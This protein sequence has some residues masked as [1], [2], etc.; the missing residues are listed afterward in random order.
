MVRFALS[1]A[2][3]A[4]LV[5]LLTGCEAPAPTSEI[6]QRRVWISDR[7]A[8]INDTLTLLREHDFPP[9]RVDRVGGV[10]VAGPTTSGQWFEFWRADSR[11]SYQSLESSLHTIRRTVTVRLAADP[12]VA[13]APGASTSPS[14]AG[15]HTVSVQ[16]EKERYSATERQVTTPL[17]ALAIYSDKLPTEQG[18]RASRSEGEHWVPLGRD[19][20]LEDYLLE[21]IVDRSG[22]A[23]GSVE[24]TPAPSTSTSPA[25]ITVQPAQPAPSEPAQPQAG[26]TTLTTAPAPVPPSGDGMTIRDLPASA[27]AGG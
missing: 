6:P 2:F 18:V 5:F 16:V 14:S 9:R 23:S 13:A 20:L 22:G 24:S 4:S 26:T 1:C 11:G 21:K 10:T 27:P 19:P 3:F 25:A 12:T 7:D 8:F 15:P 17:S